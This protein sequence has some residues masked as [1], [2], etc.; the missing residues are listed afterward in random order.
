MRGHF[1]SIMPACTQSDATDSF[2]WRNTTV[3]PATGGRGCEALPF[4]PPVLADKLIAVVKRYPDLAPRVAELTP[5]ALNSVGDKLTDAALEE[6]IA[7]GAATSASIAGQD[8][9]LFATGR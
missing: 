9:S 3:W 1:K 4:L 5:P 2:C 6:A 8:A 7:P